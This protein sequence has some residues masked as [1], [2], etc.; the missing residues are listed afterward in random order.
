MSN[1]VIHNY[2]KG[3]LNISKVDTHLDL[4]QQNLFTNS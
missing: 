4:S 1:M 2:H 3:N